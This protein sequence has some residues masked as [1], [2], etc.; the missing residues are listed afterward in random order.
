MD[1]QYRKSIYIYS[2]EVHH[3]NDDMCTL[4]HL[5]YHMLWHKYD[6][7]VVS[8]FFI[9]CIYMMCFL[10]RPSAL[11]ILALILDFFQITIT[12]GGCS[13]VMFFSCFLV[14]NIYTRKV[15]TE[16]QYTLPVW[17]CM[18]RLRICAHCSICH[19]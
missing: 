18:L 8:Q 9:C 14:R 12:P 17:Q 10:I 2:V 15:S 1:I 19:I 13:V 4:L 16:P 11:S 7:H 3:H 5:T 6:A